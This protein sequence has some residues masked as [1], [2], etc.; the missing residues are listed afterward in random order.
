MTIKDNQSQSEGKHNCF[1]SEVTY[2]RK[3]IS[4]PGVLG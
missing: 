2:D 1:N 3:G 4:K